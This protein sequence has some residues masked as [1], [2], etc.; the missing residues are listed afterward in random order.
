MES[1]CGGM[2]EAVQI[3][4]QMASRWKMLVGKIDKHRFEFTLKNLVDFVED[5]KGDRDA[6]A[7]AFEEHTGRKQSEVLSRL[8]ARSLASVGT[9]NV[10]HFGAVGEGTANDAPAINRA[11]DACH[12]ARG[13]TVFVPSGLYP[14]G[15]IHLPRTVPF[16]RESGAA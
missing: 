14:R 7:S 10:R 5:A 6:M 15:A 13:G 1:D 12:A 16:V 11:I 3:A 2:E 8:T 9:Y 4:E